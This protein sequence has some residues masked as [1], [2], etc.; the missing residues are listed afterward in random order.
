MRQIKRK[1]IILLNCW[2]EPMIHVR[3]DEVVFLLSIW[4]SYCCS[5]YFVMW[6]SIRCAWLEWRNDWM[7]TWITEKLLHQF[8]NLRWFILRMGSPE[9]MIWPLIAESW[10]CT[11]VQWVL[12][13]PNAHLT[14]RFA[15]WHFKGILGAFWIKSPFYNNHVDS[16]KIFYNC[17]WTDIFVMAI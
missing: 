4:L 9:S 13:Q 3:M 10:S 16:N 14:A 5:I 11:P 6:V 12:D 15:P 7:L 2:I 1:Q 17:I 8:K